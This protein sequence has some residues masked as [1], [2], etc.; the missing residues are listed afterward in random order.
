[1][2]EIDP[3]PEDELKPVESTEEA[4]ITVMDDPPTPGPD[5]P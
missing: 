1:M 3:K 2:A 5:G 4:P